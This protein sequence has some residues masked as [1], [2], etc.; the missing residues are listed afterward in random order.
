[1]KLR[2]IV[3]PAPESSYMPDDEGLEYGKL[4]YFKKKTT[5][6]PKYVPTL[7]IKYDG[8]YGGSSK[9]LLFFHGNAEDIGLAEDLLHH[10]SESL[11]VHVIAIEYPG[12]G[13]YRDEYS[14]DNIIEED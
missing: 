10:L 8:R 1:M 11:E 4:L 13:I 14:A 6:E 3:F 9:V 12:Y 7:L 5:E 2:N